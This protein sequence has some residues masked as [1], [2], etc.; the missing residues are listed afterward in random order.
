MDVWKD[1]KYIGNDI[2]ILMTASEIKWYIHAWKSTLQQSYLV[3][4]YHLVT[5]YKCSAEQVQ[6]PPFP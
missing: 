4:K 1:R 2:I 6:I 3:E 5:I